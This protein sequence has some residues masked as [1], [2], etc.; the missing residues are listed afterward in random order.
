[1][2]NLIK[3]IARTIYTTI[4]A[5]ALVSTPVAAMFAYLAWQE[6]RFSSHDAAA[7]AANT[8]TLVTMSTRDLDQREQALKTTNKILIAVVQLLPEAK[9]TRLGIQDLVRINQ[10][11]LA[12]IASAKKLQRVQSRIRQRTPPNRQP[13]LM[14]RL[15]RKAEEI[16]RSIEFH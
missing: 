10:S 14:A 4:T 1:M 12:S 5:L 2:I 8:K 16:W 13:D 3:K 7:T 11:R 6:A 9:A 15:N